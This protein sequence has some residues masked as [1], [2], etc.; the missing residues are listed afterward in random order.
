M[1]ES[2]GSHLQEYKKWQLG[3]IERNP[4]QEIWKK[5]KDRFIHNPSSI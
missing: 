4:Q 2:D 3:K 5:W 1:G